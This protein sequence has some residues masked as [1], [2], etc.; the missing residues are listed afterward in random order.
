MVT[1]VVIKKMG[2]LILMGFFFLAGCT[3]PIL[4]TPN[5]NQSVNTSTSH[6]ENQLKTTIATNTSTLMPVTTLIT[7]PT[8]S[9]MLLPTLDPD[10]A[11]QEIARLMETNDN[12]TG[13]CFWG[14]IPGVTNFDQ[15]VRFLKTLKNNPLKETSENYV[16]V[17]Q[18]KEN[19]AIDLEL[20]ASND[21]IQ[22]LDVT[23]VGLEL[24]NIIGRDWLAF[25]P[26]RFVKANGSPEQVNIIMSEGPEGRVGYAMLLFYD[27]MY[28]RYSG[29][30]V[31]IKPEHILHACPIADHNIQRLDLWVGPYDA[32]VKNDGES[33]ARLTSLT[34]D[35]LIE[36]L[37]GDPEKACFDLDYN[38]FDTLN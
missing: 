14:I 11:Q 24:P 35:D 17:Y 37:T 6:V 36:I 27:Q 7:S 23:I 22:I 31:I 25:R 16:S 19:A 15:A 26:D 33:L 18:L 1:N 28:V 13:A 4:S 3:Q 2:W 32:K 12:C 8:P 34:P 29:N 21:E 10:A 38:K 20:S 9:W 5:E 30:Q